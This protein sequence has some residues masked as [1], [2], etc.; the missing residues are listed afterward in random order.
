M[1]SNYLELKVARDRSRVRNGLAKMQ[2]SGI[3]ITWREQ[4]GWWASIFTIFGSAVTLEAIRSAVDLPSV[5]RDPRGQYLDIL[6]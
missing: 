1:G 6:A 5:L 2:R 3:A 4:R